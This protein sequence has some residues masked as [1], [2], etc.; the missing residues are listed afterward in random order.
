MVLSCL[1]GYH[2]RCLRPSLF[3]DSEPPLLGRCAIKLLPF[4][5]IS[6]LFSLFR[7]LSPL[8]P[9]TNGNQ[10]RLLSVL[11]RLTDAT[12]CARAVTLINIHKEGNMK[13][14]PAS[15]SRSSSL[16]ARL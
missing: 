8:L 13:Y 11:E 6:S 3:P 12:L 2:L 15:Y 16:D 10:R 14:A 1:R 5:T 7:F 4:C 9:F